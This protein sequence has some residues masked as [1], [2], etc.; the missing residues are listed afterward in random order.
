MSVVTMKLSVAEA[1]ERNARIHHKPYLGPN[2]WARSSARLA[3]GVSGFEADNQ[4]CDELVV[5]ALID[6]DTR[7]HRRRK[8]DLFDVATLGGGWL[9]SNDFVDDGVQV[10]G[11]IF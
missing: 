4:P 1:S 8:A 7:T 5:V 3:A 11:Q 10:G 2:G 9:H 6:L